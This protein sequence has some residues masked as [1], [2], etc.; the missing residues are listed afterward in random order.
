MAVGGDV[1]KFSAVRYNIAIAPLVFTSANGG[2]GALGTEVPLPKLGISVEFRHDFHRRGDLLSA[3]FARAC[4]RE[5]TEARGKWGE[6]ARSEARRCTILGHRLVDAVQVDDS[7]R[8]KNQRFSLTLKIEGVKRHSFFDTFPSFAG[9]CGVRGS[10]KV[11]FES[12]DLKEGERG[13]IA[14]RWSRRTG[15]TR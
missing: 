12:E 14:K 9:W 1:S 6:S 4:G 3:R 15:T 5:D 11:T 2:E 13:S 10:S 8:D 7:K